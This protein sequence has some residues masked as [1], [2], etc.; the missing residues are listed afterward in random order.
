[1]EAHSYINY[2][3]SKKNNQ[4]LLERVYQ[5]KGN[6]RVIFGNGLVKLGVD[7]LVLGG[8]Y[9]PINYLKLWRNSNECENIKSSG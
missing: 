6:L 4:S 3:D 1:M 2:V 9:R 5:L 7:F 8:F